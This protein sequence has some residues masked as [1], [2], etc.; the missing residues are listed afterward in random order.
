MHMRKTSGLRWSP[1]HQQAFLARFCHS[2]L[3]LL[4]AR[5]PEC[6]NLARFSR[7][8]ITPISALTLGRFWGP[9]ATRSKGPAA[10]QLP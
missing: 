7:I 10:S 2:F 6:L 8:N 5:Q 3:P 9:Q 1:A 4:P